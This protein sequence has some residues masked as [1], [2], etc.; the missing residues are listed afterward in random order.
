MKFIATPSSDLR[1][2]VYIQKAAEEPDAANQVIKRWDNVGT[3]NALITNK[4]G[5]ETVVGNRTVS[6]ST[7]KVIL[8]YDELAS[9][10][11]TEHRLKYN[12][13]VMGITNVNNV[14]ERNIELWLDCIELAQ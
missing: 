11:T 7:Y 8:R 12:D 5:R 6:R 14:E 4:G 3:R 1:S 13:R 9:T 2:V 10:I